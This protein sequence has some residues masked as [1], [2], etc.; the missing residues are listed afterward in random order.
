VPPAGATLRQGG[1]GRWPTHPARNPYCRSPSHLDRVRFEVPLFRV[2]HSGSPPSPTNGP[3]QASGPCSLIDGSL[4]ARETTR[5]GSS[6]ASL[7]TSPRPQGRQLASPTIDE[8]TWCGRGGCWDTFRV[9][10]RVPDSCLHPPVLLA[11]T[12]APARQQ[13]L[14]MHIPSFTARL[15]GASKAP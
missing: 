11:A 8:L 6:R 12:R 15:A 5:T 13:Y 14:D 10:P 3:E 1:G 7:G 4:G 2:P 9:I